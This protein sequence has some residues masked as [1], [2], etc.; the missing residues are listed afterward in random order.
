M[1]T[2]IYSPVGRRL[3][4]VLQDWV[5]ELPFM[6]QT[7]LLTAIRGPDGV[8]K[9]H[10]AKALVRFLRRCILISAFD[11]KALLN[12]YHPGGGSFTGPSI[13]GVPVGDKWEEH[14]VSVAKAFI[15]SQDSLPLHYYLHVLHAIEIVGYKH[16]D[17]RVANFW[18]HIYFVM[19]HDLHLCVESQDNLNRRLNDN[20]AQWRA[21]ESRFKK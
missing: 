11:N 17:I 15:G 13:P 9:E 3:Q 19:A 1:E 14:M 18:H 10:P 4:P 5:M 8:A 21:D 6:Q 2:G 20:E 7:V 16:S 12:P